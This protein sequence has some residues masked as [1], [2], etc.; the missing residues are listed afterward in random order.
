M[1]QPATQWRADG[2]TVDR[3]FGPVVEG[4]AL[5]S[6]E[7]FSPRY[8]LDRW[9]GI[10]TKAGHKLEGRSIQDKICF[11]PTAKGGIAAGWAFN[12]I[13]AKGIAPKAFVFGIANPV[14]VQGAIF[15]GITIT[16]G[17]DVEPAALFATGDIVRVDPARRSITIVRRADAR[18]ARR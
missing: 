13:K 10:I 6:E 7:G 1:M 9:S 3:A 5:V 17:W 15:A 14:M 11:F 8:D 12:D 16:E 18:G 2:L 4:E